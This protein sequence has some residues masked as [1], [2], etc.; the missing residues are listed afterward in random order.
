[1]ETAVNKTQ[2]RLDEWCSGEGIDFVSEEAKEAYRKRT[3]RIADA[4]LL[5]QPD[6]VP[7]VP[8]MEFFYA[9][10]ANVSAYDVMYNSE[11]ASWATKKNDFRVG[12]RCVRA[13]SFFQY[14]FFI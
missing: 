13:A 6:R 10:Y 14:R 2:Q 7:V 4:I 11:I 8:M 5:K 9:K 1:M 3:K 12:A